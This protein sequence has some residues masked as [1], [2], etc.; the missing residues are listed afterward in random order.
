[1]KLEPDVLEFFY[2]DR[3]SQIS[4]SWG[5]ALWKA[6][7]EVPGSVCAL[8]VHFS[9]AQ[10]GVWLG[11]AV[12]PFFC[13]A[14]PNKTQCAPARPTFSKSKKVPG[15][16]P[17]IYDKLTLCARRLINV[18]SRSEA[19]CF[20]GPCSPHSCSRWRN[21]SDGRT[22]SQAAL[23]AARRQ[24]AS[25]HGLRRNLDEPMRG[26][27][28]GIMRCATKLCIYEATGAKRLTYHKY[29]GLTLRILGGVENVVLAEAH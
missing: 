1:M 24:G 18:G 9:E 16:S 8:F 12:L 28:W 5:S 14:Q 6:G 19:L 25:E 21:G 20:N 22:R 7:F 17:Y 15:A 4:R 2:E 27:I 26:W 3:Q 13:V 23:R 10:R 29:R 11:F